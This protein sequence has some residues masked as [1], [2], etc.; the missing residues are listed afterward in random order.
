MTNDVKCAA[1]G[2]A[3]LGAARGADPFVYLNIG[4]G[5]SAALYA[6]GSVYQGA[7]GAAGEIAY[8]ATDPGRLDGLEP[9]CG[10]LEEAMSGVGLSGAYLRASGLR[11]GAADIFSRAERGEALATETIERGFA[12]LLP[13]IANLLT[14]ADPE[15]LVIGGGVSLGLVSR[16]AAI[17]VYVERLTPFPPKI[18]F[19]GL[20]G[21]AG[22]VGAIRLA[23]IG[24]PAAAGA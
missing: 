13:A 7:H 17:T 23:M 5:L 6:G 10:P 20:G 12:Y 24:S 18:A 15:L 19:S 3:W 21:R 9:G 16:L 1:L 14:F 11:L 22:L 2:E 8:W 4:T